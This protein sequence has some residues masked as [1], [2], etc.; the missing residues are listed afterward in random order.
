MLVQELEVKATDLN[1]SATETYTAGK[2]VT[3]VCEGA[4]DSVDKSRVE[5]FGAVEQKVGTAEQHIS[6]EGL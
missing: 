6:H 4:S 2:S 1:I 3:K 5:P